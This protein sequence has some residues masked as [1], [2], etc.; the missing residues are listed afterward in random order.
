MQVLN[1]VDLLR[2][3]AR[4]QQLQEWYTVNSP[5]A[6]VIPVSALSGQ[7]VDAVRQ[8]AVSHLPLGPSLYPKVHVFNSCRLHSRVLVANDGSACQ[9]NAGLA[10]HFLT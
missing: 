10:T 5:A 7:N 2:D 6:A 8:W 4:V 3:S 9:Y 1:K